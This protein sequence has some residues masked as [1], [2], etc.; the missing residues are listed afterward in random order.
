MAII[1]IQ[2][3]NPELRGELCRGGHRVRGHG[4]GRLD[5]GRPVR[6]RGGSAGE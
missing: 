2:P 1:Y 4:R 5:L 3:T 6:A